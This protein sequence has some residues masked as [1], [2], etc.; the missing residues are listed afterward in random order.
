V[1]GQPEA[2]GGVEFFS[3]LWPSW[4]LTDLRRR[5][6]PTVA[7]ALATGWDPPALAAFV[8]ANTSGVRS[9][10]AVLAA[11]LSPAELPARPGGALGLA[12]PP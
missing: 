11:R 9:P 6:A 2:G 5:L 4:P 7:A 12:R 3:R 10:A 8:G 1:V